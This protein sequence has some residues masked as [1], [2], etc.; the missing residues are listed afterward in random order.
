[1]YALQQAMRAIRA[2]W[3]AS[4]AT[5]TTMTLSLTILAGFSFVSLNLNAYLSTLQDELEVTTYLGSGADPAQL[6]N[7]IRSWPEVEPASVIYVPKDQALRDIVTDLPA[8]QTAAD[9]IPNPLPDSIDLRLL[10]PA[11][12]STVAAR[13]RA[14][15][16]VVGLADGSE[17]VETFLA[18]TDAL[19]VVGSILI[20]IL[21]TSG[22]LA[23]INSIRAAITGRRKEIE[24]MKLVGATR[25]FIRAPFLIEGFLLGLFSGV[26]SLALAVP[27]YQYVVN[28]LAER[29]KFVPFVRDTASLGQVTLL[30]FA[31]A[32]LV[33]LVGS[34]ISVSQHLR[35]DY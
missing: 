17:A 5:L 9:L 20:V 32:L 12:T 8:L 1:M 25:A 16:G 31:L 30:L 6:L 35:E 21:L 34:A 28:R 23:I 18:I 3:I 26:I 29:L 11:L 27:G 19:R 4:V 15:P 33:G 10:D 2:N 7:T 14:L 22:L 24:V 13:L